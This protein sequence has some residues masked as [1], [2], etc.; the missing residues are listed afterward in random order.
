[1]VAQENSTAVFAYQDGVAT[2][3][4]QDLLGFWMTVL[5][6]D[7]MPEKAGLAGDT[8]L[9]GD[10]AL[11]IAA[12]TD[13]VDTLPTWRASYPT[14]PV[15]IASHLDQAQTKL[16]AS[17]EALAVTPNRLNAFVSQGPALPALSFG[18]PGAR[19]AEPEEELSR[20]LLA[21]QGGGQM[22]SFGP[23]DDFVTEWE[24]AVE[25]F[26][27][28]SAHLQQMMSHLAQVETRVAG[29][30]VGRT[31]VTWSGDVDT[32]LLPGLPSDHMQLHRWTLATA[33]ASRR[34]VLRMSTLVVIGA[35]KL[36][37]LLSAPGG[38]ALAFP[39]VLRYIRMVQTE[40]EEIKNLK[41]E[42]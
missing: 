19:L 41:K 35:A 33:L 30:L 7:S 26:Q 34:A 5:P 9:P 16:A 32:Y 37:V 36:S 14:D 18:G 27:V 11:G 10:V 20:W 42:V 12:E 15:Q 28:F 39:A 1:M 21:V 8:M 24:R 6:A 29:R 40:F 17:Q 25:T 3:P 22:M 23:V 2:G 4:G 13:Q 31:V 38:I